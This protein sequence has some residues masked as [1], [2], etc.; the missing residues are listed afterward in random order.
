[1]D[2]YSRSNMH[3]YTHSHLD[4]YT[5]SNTHTY[6]HSNIHTYILSHIDT[7]IHSYIGTYTH[8][9]RT[10]KTIPARR[11]IHTYHSHTNTIYI[12]IHTHIIH[13]LNTP[14]HKCMHTLLTYTDIPPPEG[15][16]PT[17]AFPAKEISAS[18]CL[19][20][21]ALCINMLCGLEECMLADLRNDS[22]EL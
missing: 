16:S 19:R 2:T 22:K 20:N 10:K 13:I 14:A 4:A 5:H 6:T 8:H 9:S 18:E 1:M 7:Y 12:Y 11:H 17:C 21:D 15:T 3:T